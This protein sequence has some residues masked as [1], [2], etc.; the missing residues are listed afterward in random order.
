MAF[1]F[2]ETLLHHN[3][4]IT[5]PCPVRGDRIGFPHPIPEPDHENKQS[6][7]RTQSAPILKRLNPSVL[8]P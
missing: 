4:G 5:R 7:R 8:R 1:P 6:G 2:P 3:T